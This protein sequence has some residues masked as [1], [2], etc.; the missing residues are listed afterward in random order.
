MLF[1][2]KQAG[3]VVIA[4]LDE[5]K[6]VIPVWLDVIYQHLALHTRN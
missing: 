5:G 6:P 1:I 3:K 4:S 2:S